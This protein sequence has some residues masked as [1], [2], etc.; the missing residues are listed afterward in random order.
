ATEAAELHHREREV[1]P[2]A[3]ARQSD[4]AIE[5]ERRS[6]IGAVDDVRYPR[7]PVGRKSPSSMAA[8]LRRSRR[9]RSSAAVRS[10][11]STTD[12]SNHA[13]AGL[14]DSRIV[15]EVVPMMRGT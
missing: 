11:Q 7:L 4:L 8:L 5:C 15:P 14:R 9:F 12:L 13:S 2:V 3:L 1:D 10:C 6:F